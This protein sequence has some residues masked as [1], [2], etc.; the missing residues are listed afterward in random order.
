M[1]WTGIFFATAFMGMSC[2]AQVNDNTVSY[3]SDQ[4]SVFPNPERGWHNP[5]D[6]DGRG[7]NDD[8]DD[9]QEA[10]DTIRA[11]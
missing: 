7:G 6:V 3:I 4:A 5:S 9:L 11:N 2:S 10:L 8:L 1:K